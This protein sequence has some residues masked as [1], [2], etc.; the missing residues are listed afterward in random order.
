MSIRTQAFS[1]T[2]STTADTF[3]AGIQSE[4]GQAQKTLLAIVI[5]VS[6]WN[7]TVVRAVEGQTTKQE[8]YDYNCPGYAA[9]ASMTAANTPQSGRLEVNRVL[10]V[11]RAYKI[12][13]NSNTTAT[14]LRGYYVYEQ[15]DE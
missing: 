12:G 5:S 7:G 9:I 10:E 3:D 15:D 11:G 6:A 8:I 14:S 13:A 1:V 4:A 2:G